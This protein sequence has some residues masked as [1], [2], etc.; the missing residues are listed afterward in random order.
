MKDNKI[1][2]KPVT[3]EQLNAIKAANDTRRTD[4]YI[5]DMEVK[6]DFYMKDRNK[7]HDDWH[8][9]SAR[10]EACNYAQAVGFLVIVLLFGLA[11]VF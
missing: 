10:I 6:T 7:C 5:R 1:S 3:D 9:H 2:E 4:E 11:V 8:L